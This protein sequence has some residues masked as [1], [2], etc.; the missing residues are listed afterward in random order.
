MTTWDRCQMRTCDHTVLGG[1]CSASFGV[2]GASPPWVPG[3]SLMEQV[4]RTGPGAHTC[5]VEAAGPCF[6]A[7]SPVQG[8]DRWL[9]PLGSLAV[10]KRVMPFLSPPLDLAQGLVLLCVCLRVHMFVCT[11]V[12]RNHKGCSLHLSACLIVEM[13]HHTKQGMTPRGPV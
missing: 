7:T 11:R 9:W 13:N 5:E 4:H 12:C 3:A 6:Q 10:D 2:L 1:R 8:P